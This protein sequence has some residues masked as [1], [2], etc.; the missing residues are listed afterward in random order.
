VDLEG[1][2]PRRLR[3][4]AMLLVA[5]V[6]AYWA[7]RVEPRGAGRLQVA[8][9]V[10]AG[11]LLVGGVAGSYWWRER[12]FPRARLAAL[13]AMAVGSLAP[14]ALQ[15]GGPGN[16][17]VFLV[18]IWA[19]S[20]GTPGA[21]IAATAGAAFLAL[22]LVG[23][24]DPFQLAALA[25]A[26]VAANGVPRLRAEAQRQ[27]LE[28]AAV[29]ERERL[30]REI[31]DV[32]AHTLSALAVQLEGARLLMGERPDYALARDAVERAHRLAAEGLEETRRAVSALRGEVLP[33]PDLLPDLAAD[34]ERESGVPC[35]FEVD[36]AAVPLRPDARLAIYRTTQEALTNVRK[37]VDADQVS[38]RLCYA[39]AGAELTVDDQGRPR[40]SLAAGGHGLTGMRERAQQLGGRLEAG[41][42]E[43]GFRVRLW[44]PA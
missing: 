18:A 10:T 37:H 23:R 35:R 9:A 7:V 3:P 16:L 8:G 15:P 24:A 21:V 17:G 26:L 6:T 31:H 13:A 29:Q 28:R 20:A 34:F 5:L 38:I 1:L 14:V 11:A 30:A 41:P 43:G 32:L 22:D 44:V 40:P 19:S 2:V 36:G 4:L 42:T 39:Q 25:L 12:D 33:G 27:Q